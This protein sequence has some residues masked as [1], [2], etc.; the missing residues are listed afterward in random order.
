MRGQRIK[1]GR[2]ERIWHEGYEQVTIFYDP[3]SNT[4]SI[5]SIHNTNLGPSLGGTRIYPYPTMN[6]AL[7]DVLRLSK[8]M[9]YKA[10]LA[11]L[12]LGGGKAVIQAD[13]RTQKTTAMMRSHA[14]FVE[15]LGG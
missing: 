7:D 10:A 8:G 3:Q 6:A 2:M 14:L 11:N 9:T 12:P 4:R 1:G 5:I 15:S 13:P